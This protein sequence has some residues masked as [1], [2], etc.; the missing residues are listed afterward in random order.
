MQRLAFNQYILEDEGNIHKMVEF[1]TD[2]NSLII[3]HSIWTLIRNLFLTTGLIKIPS[4]TAP[5]T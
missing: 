3:K 4:V 2:R 1:A 5:F